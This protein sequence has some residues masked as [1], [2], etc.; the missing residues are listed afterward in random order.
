MA[1]NRIAEVAGTRAGQ[2]PER[3]AGYRHALVAALTESIQAQQE[4][5]SERGRRERVL[6]IVEALGSKVSA[7][8]K[9][10]T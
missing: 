2:V 7:Q 1:G 6:K 10:A 3:V 5:L 9:E 8:S 4:Q